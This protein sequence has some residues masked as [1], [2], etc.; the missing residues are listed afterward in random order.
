MGGLKKLIWILIL[1][2]AVFVTPLDSAA[3]STDIGQRL[4]VLSNA[5]HLSADEAYVRAQDFDCSEDALK[6]P[7]QHLWLLAPVNDVVT[8]FE[9]PAVRMLMSYH[10]ALT[11]APVYGENRIE[12]RYVTPK[13]II[14]EALVPTLMVFPVRSSEGEYPTHI[15]IGVEKSWDPANWTN[16][17]IVS[18]EATHAKHLV[19]AL[20]YA[21]IIGLLMTPIIFSAVLYAVLRY[22][23]LP[24]HV[25]TSVCALLYG[26]SWA[27]FLQL[28]PFAIE[29]IHRS[30]LNHV[31]IAMAFTG[32]AYL[33]RELCGRETLGA[34][35]WRVLPIAGLLP[36]LN[37]TFFMAFAPH[38]SHYGS[39]LIH[40]AFILPLGAILGSLI[41]GS[42][43][44]KLICKLQL[45][46]WLPMFLYVAG[47]IARGMGLIDEISILE[48]GLYPSLATEALLTTSIVGYR[49]YTLRKDHEHALLQQSIL[50]GLA[51]S[52]ALE[53]FPYWPSILI[54]S[55]PL[56]MNMGTRLAMKS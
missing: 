10:G 2:I 24:F 42:L 18:L 56:M 17:Q 43:K 21:I 36:L 41:S 3:Q 29:P 48:L 27:G 47:R 31:L 50:S 51:S 22:S 37:T 5:G 52:D 12:D 9:D 15:L 7:A 32:A 55:K 16:M 54:T 38:F 14:E 1:G 28:S 34:F 20:F 25:V 4:C 23:F 39:V 44:G 13:E 30:V 33:T 35:W 11:I 40:A 46:G 6:R 49:I 19:D 8:K 53:L 45:L 26:V